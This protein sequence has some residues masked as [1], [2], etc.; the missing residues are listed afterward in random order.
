MWSRT[1]RDTHRQTDRQTNCNKNTQYFNEVHAV[2]ARL[3]SVHSSDKQTDA[4]RCQC[5][6]VQNSM[7]I[8]IIHFNEVHTFFDHLWSVHTIFDRLWSVHSSDKQTDAQRCQC[9]V[10]QNSTSNGKCGAFLSLYSFTLNKQ[11]NRHNINAML[12]CEINNFEIISVKQLKHKL[13]PDLLKLKLRL[14]PC[15]VHFCQV[16]HSFQSAV[17]LM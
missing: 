1:D 10:V 15:V 9:C 17:H 4:Q 6:V 11:H 13:L 2:F 16:L 3:W 5:C 8:I 7:S 12:T 14:F